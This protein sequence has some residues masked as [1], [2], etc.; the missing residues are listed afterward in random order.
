MPQ[1]RWEASPI[2]LPIQGSRMLQVPQKGAHCQ[3]MQESRGKTEYAQLTQD[4]E[5]DSVYTMYNLPDKRYK[6]LQVSLSID[7]R[8]LQMETDTGASLSIISEST[9]NRLWADDKAPEL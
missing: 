5:E 3:S 7:K 6:P 8:D 1:M 9:F 2:C 4:P